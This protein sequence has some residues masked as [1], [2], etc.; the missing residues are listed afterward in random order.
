[1]RTARDVQR[2]I[3]D[4]ERL[5]VA[6]A[7][8]AGDAR[9]RA[10]TGAPAPAPSPSALED[11][12]QHL[13]ARTPVPLDAD[14]IREAIRRVYASTQSVLGGPPSVMAVLALL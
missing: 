7:M 14:A 9:R 5:E 4:R 13:P 11:A 1:V 10:Q 8:A 6:A 2:A 3:E 12:L